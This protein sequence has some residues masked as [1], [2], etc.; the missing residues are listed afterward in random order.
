MRWVVTL[1]AVCVLAGR[2]RGDARIDQLVKGYEREQTSCGVHEGGL[3]K[4]LDGA[5]M[6]LER[7]HE[8]GLAEDV[9]SLHAAHEVVASYCTALAA[10]IEFLRTDPSASYKSLEKQISDRDNHIR[11]LRASSKK[12]LDETEPLIRRWIPKINGARIENDKSA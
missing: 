10:T 12:A 5:T 7:G 3:A 2:A 1:V 11:V 9:K 4:M 8:D 6:L